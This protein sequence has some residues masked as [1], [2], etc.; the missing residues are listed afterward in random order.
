MTDNNTVQMVDQ[1]RAKLD[2][3]VDDINNAMA[4]GVRVEFQLLPDAT[5]KQTVAR[6]DCWL[7]LPTKK[8]IQ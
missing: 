5:G 1:I 8:E 2:S 3:L 4:I 7:R 6:Y